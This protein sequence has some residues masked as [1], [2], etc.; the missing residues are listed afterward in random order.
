MNLTTV[1]QMASTLMARA[2]WAGG[3]GTTYGG[4]RSISDVCGYKGDLTIQDYRLRFKRNAIAKRVIMAH[5][6]ATW[7]GGGEIIED[8][9]K[10]DLTPFEQQWTDLA[11]RLKLWRVFFRADVLQGFDYYSTILLG[12]PG[13]LN[14]QVE[15]GSL[16]GPDDLIYVKPYAADR[17]TIEEFE[18]NEKDPR[19][20]YPTLYRLKVVPTNVIPFN[21]QLPASPNDKIVHWSRVIHICDD[22]EEDIYTVPRLE[23]IWNDLDDIEK[24]K[25]G[26]AEAFWRRADAGLQ[27]DVDKEIE[28]DTE[29]EEAQ[30][31]EVEAYIHEFSR[32]LRTRGTK[33]NQLGSDVADFSGPLAAS[34]S[35]VSAGTGIPQRILMGSERGQLASTQD[36]DN[37]FDEIADRREQF[38]HPKVVQQFTDRGIE[39]GFFREPEQYMTRWSQLKSMDENQKADLGIKIATVNKYQGETVVTD[40]EIRDRVFGFPPLTDEQKKAEA[41]KL[42]AKT[43]LAV[44]PGRKGPQVDNGN[45]ADRAPN[46]GSR[47]PKAASEDLETRFE[48]LEALILGISSKP[49]ENTNLP[50]IHVHLPQKAGKQRILRDEQGNMTEIVYED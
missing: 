31:E 34:I 28:L 21:K 43:K 37:W 7:R 48:R 4:R 35:V 19:F 8:D 6:R 18:T 26:G 25:G 47:T 46:G 20:G 32:I 41:D 23:C 33:I 50:P 14:Q 29:G 1:R 45:P 16:T 15:P 42:A 3:I 2:K 12:L 22:L 17:L 10:Q 30:Q 9:K 24:I 39:L 44:P 38:A 13:T 40:D 49:A 11:E 27:L 36:R 5:P